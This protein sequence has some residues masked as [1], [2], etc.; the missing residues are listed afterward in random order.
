MIK[1]DDKM[2]ALKIFSEDLRSSAQKSVAT[3]KKA[4]EESIDALMFR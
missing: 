4:E 3:A 1:I 2:Y